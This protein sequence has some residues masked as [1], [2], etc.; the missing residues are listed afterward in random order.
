MYLSEAPLEL[1]M[2][3]LDDCFVPCDIIFDIFQRTFDAMGILCQAA[4]RDVSGRLVQVP[5]RGVK[6]QGSNLINIFV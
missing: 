1:F 4:L 3:I 6:W 2:I 5:Q